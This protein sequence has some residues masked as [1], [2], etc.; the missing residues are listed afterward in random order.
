M[1]LPLDTQALLWW[2]A[3]DNRLQSQAR[4]RISDPETDVLVSMVSLWEIVVKV[5]IGKLRAD[6]A[7]VAALIARNGF[8]LLDVRM[9]HLVTLSGLPMHH[10]D[11]FDHLLI[12]Q[13]IAE[14]AVFVSQDRRTPEY[15]VRYT[16]CSNET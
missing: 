4:E 9:S 10:R 12:S 16:T 8:T 11:P 1:K 14:D 15:A 3:N 13:A 7:S 6:I 2:V 5:R